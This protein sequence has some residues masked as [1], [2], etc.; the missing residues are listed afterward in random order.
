MFETKLH[1]YSQTLPPEQKKLKELENPNTNCG[2]LTYGAP[3][4]LS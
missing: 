1:F 4:I 3:T 2:P